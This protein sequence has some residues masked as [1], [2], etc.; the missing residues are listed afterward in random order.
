MLQTCI[1]SLKSKIKFEIIKTYKINDKNTIK[2]RF[3]KLKQLWY[4]LE[5]IF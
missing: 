5:I 1:H 2:E 4:N 3:L